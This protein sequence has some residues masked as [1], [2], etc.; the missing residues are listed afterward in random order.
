MR[1]VCR[2][3]SS[4]GGLFLAPFLSL[5]AFFFHL[6]LRCFPV[7]HL[8]RESRFVFSM[9]ARRCKCLLLCLLPLGGMTLG[10]LVNDRIWF[11]CCSILQAFFFQRLVALDDHVM[12]FETIRLDLYRLEVCQRKSASLLG[13]C[14]TTIGEESLVARFFISLVDCFDTLP[15]TCGVSQCRSCL[16]HTAYAS[17]GITRLQAR[18]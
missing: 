5:G 17:G 13:I 9:F 15:P 12:A 1:P 3:G 16:L 4:R 14:H 18:R 11:D 8:F 10:T 6:A 2:C 7:L